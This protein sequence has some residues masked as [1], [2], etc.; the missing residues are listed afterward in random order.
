MMKVYTGR[1]YSCQIDLLPETISYS[2]IAVPG[3][4]TPMLRRDLFDARFQLTQRDEAVA[5]SSTRPTL[6]S[7]ETQATDAAEGPQAVKEPESQ[8]DEEYVDS[9]TDLVP[10]LYEGGLK[11]WEGGVDLVEVLSSV[12]APGGTG[13][14]ASGAKILDVGCG[15]ALPSAFIL[16]SLL[17]A[18]SHTSP[19]AT[20]ADTTGPT[21]AGEIEGQSPITAAKALPKPTTTIHLQDFNKP[22]L[23][24]VTLPNL[25]L[26][27]LPFLAPESLKDP[28]DAE[29]EDVLPDLSEPGTLNINPMVKFAFKSLLEEHSIRLE[30]TYGHWSGLAQRM[31]E[32]KTTYDLVLTSE[33]IYAED[34]VEDLLA[35]LKAGYATKQGSQGVSLEDSMGNLKLQKWA[36]APLD[37]CTESVI[38]VA[39]KVRPGTNYATTVGTQS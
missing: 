4:S 13:A 9:S 36:Q 21:T 25:I 8:N 26:A 33:T 28:T 15:T 37:E 29:I 1:H 22:V 31:E 38:L 14:W 3:L 32:D 27:T 35:V 19:Q 39:A 10:G 34:S 18:S 6:E 2:P 30:F 24:L 16:Y 17:A 11:T 7:G 5:E 20:D 23:S 12:Q